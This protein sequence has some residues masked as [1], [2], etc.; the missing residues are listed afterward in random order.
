[1]TF[2]FMWDSHVENHMFLGYEIMTHYILSMIMSFL[3]APHRDWVSHCRDQLRIRPIGQIVKQTLI[4]EFKTQSCSDFLR[5]CTSMSI[6]YS[7]SG[8]CCASLKSWCL[9]LVLLPATWTCICWDQGCRYYAARA[10]VSSPTVHDIHQRRAYPA[11]AFLD[12]R[13][14]IP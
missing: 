14:A 10:R 11:L 4:K 9:V 6:W 7:A 1:M 2:L 3:V 13:P 5:R 12:C 8:R